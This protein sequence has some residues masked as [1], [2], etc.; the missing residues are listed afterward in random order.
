MGPYYGLP[1]SQGGPFEEAS[2]V[3]S[4]GSETEGSAAP[5][6]DRYSATA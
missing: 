6:L 2:Y 1:D 3:C 4:A 5:T